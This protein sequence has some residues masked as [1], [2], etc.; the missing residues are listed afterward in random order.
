MKL[1]NATYEL[2]GKALDDNYMIT[3]NTDELDEAGS[4]IEG[5]TQ[6]D[7]KLFIGSEYLPKGWMLKSVLANGVDVTDTGIDFKPGETHTGIEVVLTSKV[8]WI[9]GSLKVP[10]GAQVRDYTLVVFSDDPQ[11]WTMPNSRYVL[12]AQPD[13]DGRFEISNLPEGGYY[14]AA[15]DEILQEEWSDPDVLDRLKATATKVTL[16]E[17]T[18]KVLELKLSDRE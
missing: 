16:S 11:R 4:I 1:K 10:T 3:L 7:V 18:I 6:K 14:A 13:E 8:T 12:R 2:D 15:T 5:S 9:S 17:G